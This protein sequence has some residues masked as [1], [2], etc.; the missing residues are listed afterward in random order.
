LTT[1]GVRP[2]PGLPEPVGVSARPAARGADPELEAAILAGLV[3]SLAQAVLDG[4][5]TP[6][7]ANAVIDYALERALR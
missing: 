7:A 3:P 1:G 6:T 2:C 4:M 5:H